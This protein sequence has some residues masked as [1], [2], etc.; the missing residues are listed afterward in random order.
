MHTSSS[1]S[2]RQVAIIGGG[3]GGITAAKSLLEVGLTPV[4]FEQSSALGGQW[5]QGA[6]HSG[7]WPGMPANSCHIKM[8]FSDYDYPSGTPMF[9]PTEQVLA[10]L[11]GYAEQFGVMAHVRFNTRVEQLSRSPEGHY[12]LRSVSSSGEQQTELFSHVIVA[13]GRYN[14]PAYPTTPGLD[15]F[16]G[17]VLHSFDYRGRE[18]FRGQRV[19]V[20][21]N[22][23]SGL[24]IASDVARNED[25]TVISSSRKPRYI[26][27]K[28]MHG[29]PTDQLAF[30]RFA[31]YANQALPPA[32][33]AEGLK[34]IILGAVGNPADYGGLRPADSLLE[35]GVSQCHDYLDFVAAGRIQAV[36]GVRAY[37]PGTVVLT[38]GRELPV[39]AIILATGYDLHLPFLAEDLRRAVNLDQKFLDLHDFTFHP[40]LP[41]V[42]FMGMFEQIGSYF[43]SAELQARWIAGCWSGT[44]AS[45]TASEMAAGLASFQ[46]FRQFRRITTCQ[47]VAELL[48][49][50]LGV[51]PS[52]P[53]YPE[54]AQELFFG[55]LAPAQ[56]RMEGPGSQPDA[57]TRFERNVRYF[58]NGMPMPLTQQHLTELQRLAALL[59]QH[60][61]LQ[62]LMQQLVAEPVA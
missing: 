12:V 6:A 46:Q 9:P 52:L 5:N 37:T 55:L 54:L 60:Q 26:A 24:E 42:A 8:S 30:S 61:G 27:R 25:T 50:N 57:R 28:I 47:E 45:P 40:A 36:P 22:S 7:Q 33:A 14:K 56:F 10:Y 13:S 51:A 62:Q 49:T 35:A 16:G 4:L 34:Q 17:R 3:P 32:E 48:A 29:V 19:L 20:V 2:P 21:G 43:V 23:I 38:D 31:G 1:F 41:N 39:D 18:E 58:T 59:P 15:Q 44:C 53:R 11:R